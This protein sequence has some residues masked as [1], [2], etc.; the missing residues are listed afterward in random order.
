MN[1]IVHSCHLLQFSPGLRLAVSLPVSRAI[2]CP[3]QKLSSRLLHTYTFSTHTHT[4]T[5]TQKVTKVYTTNVLLVCSLFSPLSGSLVR[6]VV[7]VLVS[8][9]RY[10]LATL[11]SALFIS[12]CLN[13]REEGKRKAGEASDWG[14]FARGDTFSHSRGCLKMDEGKGEGEGEGEGKKRQKCYKS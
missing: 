7:L 1:D 9:T 8:L 5:H 4:H 10:H 6:C 2:Y 14:H 13:K 11:W 3:L 12:L